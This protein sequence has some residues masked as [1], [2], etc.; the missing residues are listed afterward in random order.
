MIWEYIYINIC[1]KLPQKELFIP[2]NT[3]QLHAYV[4]YLELS[5]NMFTLIVIYI[6]I[7]SLYIELFF[8]SVHYFGS[9]YA[10]VW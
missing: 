8:S 2:R 4:C 6:M 1:N 5:A 7:M 9:W 3:F 10:Y